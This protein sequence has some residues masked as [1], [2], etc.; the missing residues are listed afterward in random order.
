MRAPL[1]T[2][3]GYA[4][5]VAQAYAGK[6]LDA[7]GLDYL[8]RIGRAATRLDRL[9]QDVLGYT[10]VLRASVPM[11]PV[12]L[13]RLVRDLIETYPSAA[14]SGVD[15][16]IEKPLPK[17]LGNET[18]LTQCISNLVGNAVKF[19]PPGTR[20]RVCIRAELRHPGTQHETRSTPKTPVLSTLDTRHPTPGNLVR[21]WFEDNGIGIAPENHTRIFRMFEQ[22]HPSAE[23]TGTGM[24]LTI[25]RK[26]VERMGAQLGFESALG[27]GSKFWIDLTTS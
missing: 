26:A 25:A 27:K 5:I 21:V 12:D 4:Q 13:D 10:K 14:P 2:M 1:R 9:I 22:I 6:P 15:I 19:V 16:Q 24:G 8:E 20:P 23:F 7:A 18:F 11:G 3:Q 17:V